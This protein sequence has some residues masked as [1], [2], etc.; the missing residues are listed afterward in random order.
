MN[1]N[2]SG[3][4]YIIDLKKFEKVSFHRFVDCISINC[5]IPSKNKD[6]IIVSSAFVKNIKN[7]IIRGR[8]ILLEIKEENNIISLNMKKYIEGGPYYFINCSELFFNEYF[9]TSIHK[10]NNLIKLKEDA[11]FSQYFQ[12][13][14]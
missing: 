1:N 3:G 13:N 9:F 4:I 5:F 11:T 2:T 6:I 12:L 10:S 7:N 14:Q 8:L